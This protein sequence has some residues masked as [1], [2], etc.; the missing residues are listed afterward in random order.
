M[1]FSWEGELIED[2]VGEMLKLWSQV[3]CELYTAPLKRLFRELEF[4]EVDRVVKCIL[5]MHDV[6]KLTGIY[7][8]YLKGGGALRGYRHEVVS[9]AITAIEF[10]QHSWAVYAAAAVLLSH[11]PILLGQVSRAGERYFTVTS[12][13]RSLQLAAGGSEIVR[14]EEDGVRVVNRMLS[15]EEFSERLSL[16]YR[17]EECMRA[18]KRVVARTSLI[19]DRHLARV[20][21]AALTHILTL[22]DSLSASKSRRDDDGGTFVSRHARLAEVGEVWRGL[23]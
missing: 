21:V 13:H 7:Q 14:L 9:S 4:G 15:G 2:H 8:S 3:Y 16:D 19:G 17:V 10:S 22:L 11:E 5:I 12:A 20:R 6:G 1:R 18:L 23:T